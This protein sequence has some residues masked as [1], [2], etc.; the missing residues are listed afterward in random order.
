MQVSGKPEAFIRSEAQAYIDLYISLGERAEI[1]LPKEIFDNLKSFV[2]L[3]YEEPNDPAKQQAEINE[4]ILKFRED[5]PGYVDVILM[6]MPHQKS[7]AFRYSAARNKFKKRLINFLDTESADE[8]TSTETMNIIDNHDFSVG[9]PPVTAFQIDFMSQ[10]QLGDSIRDL[11][12]Y[13]DVIGVKGNSEEAHWNY[14]M[15][16]LNQMITQSTHYTTAAER[17]DFLHRSEWTVNFKG[18]GGMN[19]TV[20][21]G[22]ANTAVDLLSTEVFPKGGVKVVSGETSSDELFELMQN[23]AMSV[24]V[25]KVKHIR[26]NLY[27]GS[28]WFP[29]LS[30]LVVIDDSP[31]SRSSNTSLVFSF[32]NGIISTLDNVHGKKL[33][34]AANT[35]LNI[36]LILENVC[37]RFIGQFRERVEFKI[38]EYKNELQDLKNE[39]LGETENI[40]KNTTLYK[41]DSFSKQILKDKYSLEKLRDFLVFLE[42][43]RN[44]EE[45]HEQTK[46]LIN[47]FESRVKKYFYSG[48]PELKIATVVEGG[49][50]NQIRAYG[51]YL[52]SNERQ[53]KNL[54]AKIV[55]RC[56]VILD[57]IP[58]NYQRTL[59][60]HF[61]K[62]FGINLF[63]E[64]YQLFLAKVDNEA[65]NKGRYSNFLI[66]LG[67]Y[68]DYI[69]KSASEKKVIGEFL[70]GLGTLDK[71]SISDSAQ[72]IIL[73]MLFNAGRKPYLIYN[74][75]LAW[76][77]TD[78]FPDD[79][80]YLN[81]FDIEIENLPDGRIDY[82]RI[83]NQLERIK[84]T[85]AL[86]D[87]TGSLW[88]A[89]CENTTIIIND[90]NNPTGYSDFNSG[91]VKGFLRFLNSTKITLFLDE[92]Y[93]DAVKIKDKELPKW[94]TISRY[95][96]NNIS[97]MSKIRV[98]SS[99]STTKNLGATGNR[100][101]SLI[102]TPGAIDVIE[103]VH[104]Q[105]SSENG[106]NN[107]LLM[108]NNVMAVAQTAKKIKDTI[109]AELPRNASRYKIKATLVKFIKKQIETTRLNN[110]KARHFN[111]IA[112]FE[113]SP[114]HLFL[115]NELQSLDKLD[116]LGL[117]DDFKYSDRPFYSYYMSH[118]K[119]ELSRFRINKI[120]RDESNRR[121]KLAKKAADSVIKKNDYKNV[122]VVESDG[123]YL[124]NIMFHNISSYADLKIYAKKLARYRGVAFLPYRTGMVR[125]SLGG[126]LE[127]IDKSYSVFETE[128]ADSI[129]VFLK[130]WEVFK[131]MRLKPEN[132]DKKTEAIL[133]KI[134][135]THSE[136]ELLEQVLSDFP[137]SRKLKKDKVPD[138]SISNVRSMYHAAPS[139][140]G[141]S[142]NA[143]G[144]S[145]NSVFEFQ[146]NI[147][148]CRTV[149]EFI[150]SQAFTKIYETLLVQIHSKIPQLK[151]QSFTTVVSK[152]GKATL[153]K[154]I[155]NKKEFRPNFHV[156]DKAEEYHTMCEIL[157]EMENLLFADS[158]TKI[159][160]L[161]SLAD[162][163][164]DPDEFKNSIV[165]DT[166]RMEGVNRVLRKFIEEILLHFN[167]PFEQDAIEPNR[168][169]IF[170]TT[171]EKFEE[172]TGIS[173]CEFN[174]DAYF[175]VLI[176]EIRENNNY[177][178]IPMA[179]QTLGTTLGLIN[180]RILSAD[181]KLSEKILYFY[182]LKNDNAFIELLF[183]KLQY[184]N[185]KIQNTEDFEVRM[186]REEVLLSIFENEL[187]EILD[188]IFRQKFTKVSQDKLHNVTRKVVLFFI[189]LM[190]ITKG[191]Q[192]YEKYTHL[193]VKMVEIKYRKQNSRINEMIQH[194]IS[195]Y[196]NFKMKNGLDKY[197]DGKLNWI[198]E[199]M[200]KC[201]VIAGERPV[202]IRTR[203]VSDA[204]KREYPFHKI[205]R[206]DDER[207]IFV[208]PQQ[209]TD[210]DYIKQLHLKPS[211]ALFANRMA[212]FIKNMDI[213]DY[214]CKVVNHGLVKELIVFQKSYIK[215]MT[216]NFRLNYYQ[217]LS[218]NEACNFVPDVILFLGA[219]EKVISF[220]QIGYFD[221]DGPNGKIKT[222]VTPLKQQVDYF[223]D[224]KKPRLTVINEKIKEMGGVPKH[225]S[226]FAVEE[227][228]GSLFVV[229][230]DGDSGVG[231]S[232]MVAALVLKWLRQDLQGIRS[233]K[234]IAGDM[235]HEF[236]DAE[237]NLY[238]I[239][240]EVG[241]FSHITDFDPDFIKYYRY[242]FETSA[243]SNVEDLNSRAT[244]SGLCDITMPFKIDIILTAHNY[245]KSEAGITRIDN[246][247]NF[248]MYVD[249][250]GERKEK[251]TSQD[252][253]H[254]QRT[255]KRYTAD[256]R[257]V[258]LLAKHGNY[259]DDI[260]DWEKDE[261]NGNWYLCSS[262]RMIDKIDIEQ[263]VRE[264]FIEK[265]FKRDEVAY[266]VASTHFDLIKNRFIAR[267]V[268][269]EQGDIEFVIDRRFFSLI[270]DALAST[271]GGQPFIAEHG[272]EDSIKHLINVLK[273]GK[274]GQGAGSKIQCAIL[275]TE[276]GKKGK[277]ISGPQK[278]AEDLK[279]LIQEVRILN[280]DI[281][282]NKNHVRK[283]VNEKYRH[284]F[285]GKM[286]SSEI[287]RYNFYLYQ[288]DKMK[289]ADFRRI[290]DID[291]KVNLN[292][293]A[294]FTP[295]D[296]KV[297]FSPLLVT[298]DLNV[299]ISSLS[300]TYM[301]LM[302]LPNYTEF[303]DEFK[304][305]CA[306]IFIAKGYCEET[307]I[308]NMIV[309]LLLMG[310]YIEIDDIVRGKVAEKVNRE[311]IAAAKF[312]VMGHLEKKESVI[313]KPK[314]T[315]KKKT[316]KV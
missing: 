36:R 134:F 70:A 169:E 13:R 4:Y 177:Q 247:E 142:I 32:H 71:T 159:L 203:I 218:L 240:T 190:N 287:W 270:F 155:R 84:N 151:N 106:N 168:K 310:D 28:K 267:A 246:P 81:P 182:L 308:N 214:R 85:L 145:I 200:T 24:F 216:D 126:Y 253:P 170:D 95:V 92:A 209:A 300:E 52:L 262:Y 219:P 189:G 242:L 238:G 37:P 97:V 83:I 193:L 108:L 73:D 202:Q 124:L 291:K 54:P 98:V 266:R 312:A 40:E 127:G 276:I 230:I 133:R 176:Q 39:Q 179:H 86:F 289:K 229:E 150:S 51:E 143:I 299:E 3:C 102:G 228:D 174:L 234:L 313:D 121:L 152:F 172:L 50:R 298:P 314:R 148:S 132:K 110:K 197:N 264:I 76:E 239:G 192:Y 201:G 96:M 210:N 162:G 74:Q 88:D 114:L 122:S 53:V 22:S 72:M 135:K 46:N 19:R 199:L 227:D 75:Q 171:L 101:G 109:E 77:Y 236:Q 279:R 181:S 284:I 91:P 10:I 288:L 105:N 89:F 140:S 232:E 157:I 6:L 90:P 286:H 117:P 292:D 118:L 18:L 29:L 224:V 59:R 231:K 245:S 8:I 154:Y 274:D 295:L 307:I 61:H 273:G 49:G 290:D 186:I 128:L 7:K 44:P 103:Y 244:I 183:R 167:L 94:R 304:D 78:L 31:E 43:S 116:V 47:E 14:L 178:S 107:S 309:Q 296:C 60:N 280:P 100:L 204:K 243:E 33:G 45:R 56:R 144:G 283:L 268:S 137:L 316:D 35:Q 306:K 248:L 87:E 278:A 237:G 282:N 252:G 285:N 297:E 141:V 12:K 194:G 160:A 146:G 67:I 225:G 65:D 115:L 99:L 180:R 41:L 125:I 27:A 257:I 205:D 254:F 42:N 48:N 130:Y 158:K 303:A 259:L 104:E 120:F 66:D 188:Y 281:R 82:E 196:R 223:G 62:N 207:K 34:S 20:V 111:K 226:L 119:K 136:K 187:D 129:N 261:K 68:K 233:I 217:D 211:S 305:D 131:T 272:Q 215:Y 63:L 293:I 23:N 9:T 275:S 277:E 175:Q 5:I 26:K 153:L 79:R 258:N 30:R 11:R 161:D 80:F 17:A 156:L 213:D 220:P 57:I 185:D 64:K 166:T 250:H 113:G 255:L 301:D 147:G 2:R 163:I 184:L 173:S 55:E 212:S 15:D 1:F 93:Q 311:T 271:P 249:S 222:I 315:K 251:A 138:V 241:D 294:G 235:F 16:A 198:N 269:E 221:I 69:K 165:V 149:E 191:T 195:I 208:N 139:I 58:T 263:V 302:S 206:A 265:K 256:K 164:S 260:L 112:E 123:S 38:E 21:S 25:V